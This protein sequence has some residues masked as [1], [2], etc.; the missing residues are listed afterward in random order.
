MNREFNKM[1]ASRRFILIVAIGLVLLATVYAAYAILSVAPSTGID[2]RTAT[3]A[4]VE[5]PVAVEADVVEQESSYTHNWQADEI[6]T[7][8]LP[9]TA[10]NASAFVKE[11]DVMSVGHYIE[12]DRANEAAAP[13]SAQDFYIQKLNAL[14]GEEAPVNAPSWADDSCKPAASTGV[15]PC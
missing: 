1:A 3:E 13:L 11:D 15:Q 6:D 4:E 5:A 2:L 14:A 7:E 9:G 12:R 10:E 8:V